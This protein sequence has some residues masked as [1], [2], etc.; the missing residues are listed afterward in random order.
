[1]QQIE[2]PEWLCLDQPFPGVHAVLER[3]GPRHRMYVV[4]SRQSA[5]S[6]LR[7]LQ[8]LKLSAYFARVLVTQQAQSKE[9]L[10]SHS[11]LH[12]DKKDVVIGDTGADI[13]LAR[14]IGCISVAVRSGFRSGE[15]LETYQPDHLIESVT[16]PRLVDILP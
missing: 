11:G 2:A 3:L 6:A 4:T 14:A 9:S 13:R 7:Q 12:V 1:M 16:D 10:L 5:S 15:V 8:D